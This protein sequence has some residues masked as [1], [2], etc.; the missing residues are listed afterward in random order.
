MLLE[1]C[2]LFKFLFCLN[3][4]LSLMQLTHCKREDE[5]RLRNL[6]VIDHVFHLNQTIPQGSLIVREADVVQ[7]AH[8]GLGK[9]RVLTQ[10]TLYHLT[11]RLDLDLDIWYLWSSLSQTAWYK[12]GPLN[13]WH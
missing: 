1:E 8:Y 2:N 10:G 4:Q 13:L 7:D 5:L 11:L 12:T 6:L 9:T 3:Q